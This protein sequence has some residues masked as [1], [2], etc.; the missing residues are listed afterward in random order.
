MQLNILSEA[1]SSTARQR[2]VEENSISS[3]PLCTKGAQHYLLQGEQ[4]RDR[5]RK[6]SF[7]RH[8]DSSPGEGE[9]M[10]PVKPENE[11]GLKQRTTDSQS[12]VVLFSCI[13]SILL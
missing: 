6:F 8:V 4:D 11:P 2:S 12:Q 7:C 9:Q 1:I 3:S 5:H 13:T 10:I